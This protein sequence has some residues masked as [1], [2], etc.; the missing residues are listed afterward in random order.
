MLGCEGLARARAHY[1]RWSWNTPHLATRGTLPLP[2]WVHWG[3]KVSGTQARTVLVKA[4]TQ[5]SMKFAAIVC[6]RMC[7]CAAGPW[8]NA[9]ALGHR[10]LTH[11]PRP[12]C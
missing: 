2:Q 4:A 12:A 6:S 11:A 1:R 8:L 3:R 10:Y 7:C 5:P 9:K